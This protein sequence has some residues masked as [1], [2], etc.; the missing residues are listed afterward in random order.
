MDKDIEEKIS[1][2]LSSPEE[3]KKIM[4]LAG[5][6]GI[7]KNSKKDIIETVAVEK[8]TEE[9]ASKNED[10][11][12]VEKLLKSGKDERIQLLT[13]LKPYLSGAKSEKIDSLLRIV[14]AAEILLSAK[15][16]L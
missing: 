7:G 10:L 3:L 16:L 13:A 9:K 8:T 14:N 15:N 12:A 11:S 5:T 2:I 4:E 1:D 6:L